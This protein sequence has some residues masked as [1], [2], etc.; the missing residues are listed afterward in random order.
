[1]FTDVSPLSLLSKN[2]LRSYMPLRYFGLLW[3]QV[4]FK[5]T[6]ERTV[7]AAIFVAF[8]YISLDMILL[9]E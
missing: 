1:L 4:S 2:S 5:E 7:T 3:V 6:R 9:C 8:Q